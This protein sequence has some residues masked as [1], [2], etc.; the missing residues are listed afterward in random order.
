MRL[1]LRVSLL[2]G[3][4]FRF[5]LLKSM[6]W[7]HWTW[8]HDEF[9]F[10]TIYILLR[11]LRMDRRLKMTLTTWWRSVCLLRAYAAW[12]LDSVSLRSP[13]S[14]SAPCLLR[15]LSS[16]LLKVAL[17]YWQQKMLQVYCVVFL[18]TSHAYVAPPVLPHT[19]CRQAYAS[20]A[21]FAS[22]LIF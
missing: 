2:M 20:F 16:N 9:V 4:A 18:V 19:N 7:E 1:P 3:N 6:T 14:S 13:S 8:F 12:R 22:L 15:C 17:Y 10:L 5:C 11:M 21:S